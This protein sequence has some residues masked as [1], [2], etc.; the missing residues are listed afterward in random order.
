[1]AGPK[2]EGETSLSVAQA[3][4]RRDPY[5]VLNVSRDASDQEIKSAYRKLA[6]KYHP[7]KNASNP[8]ASELF[9]EVA[10]S[11]NILSDPEKRRQYDNAG[12]EA[13]DADGTDME[14]DLSNLGTVNTMF[15]ALFSKL[16][17]PIKTT[18]SA[19]VLEEAL[20]GAVTVKPLPLGSSISGKVDK[21]FAHFFDVTVTAEQ[22]E[23]GIV[24]RV[25][26]AAQS[27]FKLL[28]FEKDIGGGYNLSLQEDSEKTGKV[29]SAGMYFLHFQV[30][31]MD[32]SVNA[33]EIAKDPETAFFK[34]L[35]GLQPCEV[36]EINAGT[37]TFAV[38]ISFKTASYTIEALCAATY[39]SSTHKLKDV[40]QQ[41]L[42]KRTE[43]RRFETDYRKALAQYQEVTNRYTLEKQNVEELLKQR[44]SI[45]SAFTVNK[46]SAISGSKI[47]NGGDNSR[48]ESK[49][50][51]EDGKDKSAKKR[52]FNLSLKLSADKKI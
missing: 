25:T 43:L 11:Y 38:I 23:A 5:E 26:S 10:Y 49:S 20:T 16:G 14:I 27:K 39:E 34:K 33:L 36:M 47:S 3:V 22:A 35:E 32:S 28:Y 51:E 12:F 50:S 4:N 30:Y 37:H 44:D 7:D 24:V 19:N 1:M 29:T 31:R 48:E 15:A 8:E 6:L 9:K 2:V 17:I 13:V 42:T 18:I 52:W 46:S 45:Q 41:I 21:Q 40:E